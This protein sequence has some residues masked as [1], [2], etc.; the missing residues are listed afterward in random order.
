M[1]D[2]QQLNSV[3]RFRKQT[4]RLVLEEYDNCEVPA[5][6]G[7]VVLRWRNPRAAR[8]VLLYLYTPV[9]ARWFVDGKEPPSGRLDLAPG[10]HVFALLLEDVDLSACLLLFVANGDSDAAHC[11]PRADDPP[12]RVLS[13]A[14][15]TWRFTLEQPGSDDWNALAFDAASWPTLAAVP[16]PELQRT[17]AGFWHYH[18]CFELG[19]ACLGLPP[20]PPGE[21]RVSWWQRLFGRRPAPDANLPKKGSV[22]IRKVFE[23]PAPMVP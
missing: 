13:R 6:C 23:V 1:S 19:A 8:P 4:G 12:F 17:D 15:D 16:A 2:E 9:Q 18:K 20:L 3:A 5:G 21:E 7:G 11:S 22:W 10:P 14:D